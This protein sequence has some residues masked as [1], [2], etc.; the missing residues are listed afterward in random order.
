MVKYLR[1]ITEIAGQVGRALKQPQPL[2]ALKFFWREQLISRRYGF[3][4]PRLGHTRNQV[5]S[6]TLMGDAIHNE[7]GS[8]AFLEWGVKKT[9]I[10][11][12]EI[13]FLDVGC[14]SGCMVAFVHCLG[15]ASSRGIDLDTE[16]LSVAK[17]NIQ[18]ALSLRPAAPG[19]LGIDVADA[20]LFDFPDPVNMI[21]LFNPFGNDT[22]KSFLSRVEESLLRNPRT[23][24]LIYQ[25][26]SFPNSLF[27]KGWVSVESY[28]KK[29]SP[30]ATVFK[31]SA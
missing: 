3:E 31:R 5:N 24:H 19:N 28:P 16:G 25:L 23:I 29:G 11:S 27:E 22:F 21:F 4:N 18:K 9:G 12:S 10:D 14:G 7:P 20:A 8:Y 2:L 17:R 1:S 26:P 15:A 30:V 6:L 13:H